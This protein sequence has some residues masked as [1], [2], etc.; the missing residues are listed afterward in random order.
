MILA[1]GLGIRLR[2]VLDDRPKVLASVCGRPFLAY[3]LDQLAVSGL[4]HVV[5]CTGYLGD[6]INQR[7]GNQY[8]PLEL[9]YSRETVPLGTGGALRRYLPLLR[10]DPVLVM[11]GDSFCTV[12][13]Q[14]VLDYHEMMIAEVTLVITEVLDTGRFGQVRVGTDG[15]VLTFQEKSQASGPGWVNGG[16]YLI[17]R[18]LLQAIPSEGAVSLENEM[19][20]RW[21]RHR[22]YA[23]ESHGPFLD[24]GTPES[25][26]AAEAFFGRRN[27]EGFREDELKGKY[28]DY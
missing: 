23:H 10:S 4:K 25:Y 16:I 28:H 3:P 17:S 12:N 19:F 13:L 14:D 6:Q 2:S 7:F 18:S 27:G 20:P 21:V 5:L 8:G 9:V 22:F 26:A 24:I 11:N 1:G 15:R